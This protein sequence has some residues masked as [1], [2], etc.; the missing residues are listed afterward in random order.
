M[1]QILAIL[2]SLPLALA[3]AWGA[4]ALW[5]RLPWPGILRP[6][7]VIG[8]SVMALGLLILGLRGVWQANIVQ[9][10][11]LAGLLI[12]WLRLAPAHGR[13]WSDDVKHLATGEGEG[14][15]LTLQ[16]VRDV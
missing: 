14:N 2:S 13:P 1:I 7:T 15:W 16:Q 12:W 4:A 6:L 9:L 11:M 3:M 8:W 10:L 5:F